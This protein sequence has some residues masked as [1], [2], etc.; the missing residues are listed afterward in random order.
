MHFII[1]FLII[2]VVIGLI[3]LIIIGSTIIGKGCGYYVR[4]Q[5][6]VI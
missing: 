2:I 5:F 6:A 4:G 3:M 1:F